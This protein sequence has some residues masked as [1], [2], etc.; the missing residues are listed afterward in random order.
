[1]ASPRNVSEESLNICWVTVRKVNDL[2]STTTLSLAQGLVSYGDK[3]T[4]LNPDNKEDH[5]KYPWTHIELFKSKIKGRQSS[6]IAKS[7]KKWFNKQLK[8]NFDIVLIDW[9]IAKFLLPFLEKRGYNVILIDRS[10]PADVSLFAKLQW[11]YWKSAWK[12][13]LNGKISAGCVVSN[14]H[15]NFV[16]QNFPIPLER[17][18]VLP[19]GV[20]PELFVNEKKVSIESEIRLVY[21]GRLDK[22]RGVLALPMLAHKLQS[23]TNTKLTMIGE[24]DAFEQLKMIEKQNTWLKIYPK[25]KHKDVAKILNTQHIGLLPMPDSKVWSLASPLK[26]SEYLSSGLLVYGIKHDGHTLPNSDN[27]W[28]RL[29]EKLDFHDLGVEWIES[30]ND[31]K[32]LKASKSSRKYAVE[33]CSWQEAIDELDNAIQINKKE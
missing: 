13:V 31:E 28:L 10:P 19:A 26:R 14:A 3:L 18:H 16:S 17:I 23:N 15:K 12:Y 8:N 9:Q 32:F 5:Q 4:F 2:C 6:S 20:D 30:L 22:H 27:S 21:H 29:V 33:N 1:M 24:G 7:A 11:R 25:M